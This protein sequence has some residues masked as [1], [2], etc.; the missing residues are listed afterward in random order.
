[1]AVPPV[2]VPAPKEKKPEITVPPAIRASR[3]KLKQKDTTRSTTKVQTKPSS[4]VFPR[5][6]YHATSSAN[7]QIIAAVQRLN[8][9]EFGLVYAWKFI[10]DKKALR[11]SG[12]RYIKGTVII[13]FD[14]GASFIPDKT[15]RDPYARLFGPVQSARPGG[16]DIWNVKVVRCY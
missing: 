14:T 1:M 6:Y 9:G 10:P 5:T 4:R 11:L 16:I 2:P 15:V 8:G 12:A 13:S 3:P 7:A